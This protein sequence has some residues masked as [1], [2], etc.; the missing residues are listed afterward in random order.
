MLSHAISSHGLGLLE[1]KQFKKATV[2]GYIT[3]KDILKEE[4]ET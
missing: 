4:I 1:L 2:T 3:Q